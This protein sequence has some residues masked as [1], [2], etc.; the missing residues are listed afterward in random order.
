MKYPAIVFL[1]AAFSR[2][3]MAD[4]SGN[5]TVTANGYVNFGGGSTTGGLIFP[6]SSPG[7]AFTEGA[8]G[9]EVVIAQTVGLGGEVGIVNGHSFF[10][11][12]SLD[13]SFH[14]LR[15]AATG[16][17]DPFI[18]GGYTKTYDLFS[19]GN[20]ANFGVGLNYWLRRHFGVRAEF[21]DMVFTAGV[22]TTNFWAIRGGLVFR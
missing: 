3:A 20:G 21:R 22:P 2:A 11:F 9:G 4:Q 13:A 17:V 8:A 12:V 16:K 1:A 15:H 14:L 7:T 18:T 10:G 5:E 19:S 6:S